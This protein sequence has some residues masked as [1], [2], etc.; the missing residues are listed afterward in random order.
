MEI[1]HLLIYSDIVK[2]PKTTL[3]EMCVDLSISD[4]GN[5]LDLSNRVWNEI[6][7]SNENK[8]KIT[9]YSNVLL[10]TRGSVSWFEVEKGSLVGL[11][12]LILEKTDIFTKKNNYNNNELDTTP[13]I[14]GGHI[15]DD[16]TYILRYVF[17]M[18]SIPI[19]SLEG[20]EEIP[21]ISTATVFIDEANETL[22]VR[23]SQT[24][25]T[26]VAK[27]VI[28]FLTE[29]EN[30][31]E[32]RR[33][34]ILSNYENNIGKFANSING[35]FKEAIDIPELMLDELEEDKISIIGDVLKSIDK[36]IYGEDTIDLDQS[37][38]EA[39]EAFGESSINLS[40]LSLVLA[41]L[42]KV[43]L[44]SSISDIRE[45][46]L[47]DSLSPYLINKGGFIDYKVIIDG[48]ETIGTIQVGLTTN[49]IN[50]SQN[51]SEEM[52]SFV[53][54]SIYSI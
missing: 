37:L 54:K 40:F 47:Y 22:E 11:K 39:K 52:I 46:P 50:F 20:R 26:K 21:K 24:V 48:V 36:A 12:E 27:E 35:T 43:Q 45:S 8:D 49:T 19:Y 23:S 16:G 41:G 31:I 10:A 6:S 32:I 29:I 14:F 5:S 28:S 38:S 15:N 51:T 44:G 33:K 9:K 42:G 53:R 2:V 3:I 25:S 4:I 17:R 1:P 13:Q 7:N 18:G 34:E 30:P